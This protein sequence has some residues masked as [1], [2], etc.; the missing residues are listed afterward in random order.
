MGFKPGPIFTVIMTDVEDRQLEGIILDPE[1]ARDYVR[2][3]YEVS[4]P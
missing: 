2:E 3:T 4:V 1:K